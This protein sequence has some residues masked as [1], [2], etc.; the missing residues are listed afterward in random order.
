MS[1]CLYFSRYWG[2][3][4][5]QLLTR[6]CGIIKFENN[7]IFLIKPFWYMSEKPRQKLKYFENKR[8]F[9][10]EIKSIFHHFK[11]ASVAKNCLRPE[12]A[13]LIFH[14]FSFLSILQFSI[15][16]Y[17]L[18]LISSQFPFFFLFFFC[19]LFYETKF[20]I[21]NYLSFPNL[22]IV[23][24]HFPDSISSCKLR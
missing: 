1:D 5:L 10:D 11:G 20:A 23:S 24:G 13:P 15:N 14:I 16:M 2:I 6:V 7:L 21:Q 22:P 4:V 12:N 3:Y 17:K 18:Y 19:L 8:S 9:S